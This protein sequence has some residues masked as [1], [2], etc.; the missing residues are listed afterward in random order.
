MYI[1][2]C[3]LTI[4]AYDMST[5]KNKKIILRLFGEGMLEQNFE[6]FDELIADTFMNH[7]VP[8]PH[9]GPQG[10]KMFVKQFIKAFPDMKINIQ[11]IIAEGDTVA[12]RG[13]IY[14]T[15]DGEFMGIPPTNKKIR[16]DYFDFWKIRDGKCIENWVQMDM[17]GIIQQLGPLQFA[18]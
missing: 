2:S 15:H 9:V 10:Y 13:F 3:H 14:G 4:N 16:I 12:T 8:N 5:E 11:Q 7:G 6:V 18:F 17:A 1:L